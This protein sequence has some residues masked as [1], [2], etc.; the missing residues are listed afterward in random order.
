MKWVTEGSCLVVLVYYGDVLCGS[1]RIID[2]L[3]DLG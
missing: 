3:K 1:K 2:K